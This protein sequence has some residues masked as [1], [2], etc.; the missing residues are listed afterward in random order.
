MK[1]FIYLLFLLQLS[2]FSYALKDQEISP[3][4]CQAASTEI[5]KISEEALKVTDSKKNLKN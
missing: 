5:I 3:E 4:Q 2:Q 1:R